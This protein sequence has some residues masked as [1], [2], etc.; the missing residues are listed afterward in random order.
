MQY[1]LDVKDQWDSDLISKRFWT[2][3]GDREVPKSF[4]YCKTNTMQ[5]QQTQDKKIPKKEIH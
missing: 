1:V 3:D 4:R 2:R 5:M